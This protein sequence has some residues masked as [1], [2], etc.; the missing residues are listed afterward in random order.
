MKLGQFERWSDNFRLTWPNEQSVSFSEG[1]SF[2][3]L[4]EDGSLRDRLN[5]FDVIC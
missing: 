3:L 1:R 5:L 4:H 2:L